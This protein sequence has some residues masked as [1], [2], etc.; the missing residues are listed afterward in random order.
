MDLLLPEWMSDD[1]AGWQTKTIKP[2]RSNFLKSS[3]N[4]IK[5]TLAEDMASD[6]WAHL[7]GWLQ[8]VNPSLKL[9]VGLGLLLVLSIIRDYRFLLIAWS[10]TV[11]L[12]LASRLPVLTMQKRIWGL[13]PLITLLISLP[14]TLNIVSAGTPLIMI[15]Q[16]SASAGS[17][18]SSDIY[19]TTQ[20]A[21]AALVLF[22]R[23][24]ISLSVACLLVMTTPIS[25]LFK[26]L[27]V[28]RIPAYFIFVVEMSYRYMILLLNLSIDMYEARRMRTVGPM[29]L[30]QQLTML[31]S[32]VGSLFSWSMSLIEEVFQAM[33]ARCYVVR[34][35]SKK[36]E[37]GQGQTDS[38]SPILLS[39]IV[40]QRGV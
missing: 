21:S 18:V 14:A 26:A 1:S 5:K 40:S 35:S 27:Q 22:L 4:N 24:G 8:T 20:G 16:G 29:S 13:I 30:T 15:L 7:P 10:L 38:S 37:A 17:I 25:S 28:F 11:V 6:K 23:T 9:A 31:G 19:V 32:S 12:M 34:Y 36:A 33:T 2:R 39:S 3:L